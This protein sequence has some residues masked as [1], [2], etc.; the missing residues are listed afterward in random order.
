MLLDTHQSVAVSDQDAAVRIQK[1]WQGYQTRKGKKQKKGEEKDKKGKKKKPDP[2]PP[3][4]KFA[5]MEK[6]R[7]KMEKIRY[8]LA[9]LTAKR[10]QGPIERYAEEVLKQCNSVRDN[11]MEYRE[12]VSPPSAAH[13]CCV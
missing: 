9:L 7:A 5:K 6:I 13:S 12:F 11:V 3:D 10:R 2:D 8:R 1:R 4:P